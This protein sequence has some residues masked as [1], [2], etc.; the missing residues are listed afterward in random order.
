MLKPSSVASHLEVIKKRKKS[1]KYTFGQYQVEYFRVIKGTLIFQENID[2]TIET[3]GSS[4]HLSQDLCCIYFLGFPAV[5][6][7][8]ECCFQLKNYYR[9]SCLTSYKFG[10]P[11][12]SGSM[13]IQSTEEMP[14]VTLLVL[15]S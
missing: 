8:Q 2:N 3:F 7:F 9:A 12:E 11:S 4:L 14:Q 10:Q 6:S 15:V 13:N 1:N 5:T